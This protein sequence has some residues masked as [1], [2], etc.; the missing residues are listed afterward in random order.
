MGIAFEESAETELNIQAQVRL[1]SCRAEPLFFA[2]WERAVFIHYEVDA[3]VLQREVPFELDLRESK[4]YVSLV[5]FT[6]R[7]LRPRVGGLFG[8]WLL[9]PIATLDYLNVRTY[10]R[11]KGEPGIYFLAEWLNNRLSVPLGPLAF[12][13]PYRFGRLDYQHEHESGAV[14]GIICEPVRQ[15]HIAYRAKLASNAE[16]KFSSPGSLDEF[17]LERYTAFTQWKSHRRFFRI[18]HPPWPQTPIELLELEDGL[19]A[20]TGGW[21]A[22]ARFVGA[23]YSPGVHNVWMGRPHGIWNGD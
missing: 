10:V 18:W 12:G 4:A 21:L 19:L 22:N 14:S 7:W 6:M 5:A 8:A 15:L 3:E 20:T 17:L 16:F 9:R 13:L 2:D 1:L 23:N 11:C